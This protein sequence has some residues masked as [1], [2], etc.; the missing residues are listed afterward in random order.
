M[1]EEF[2]RVKYTMTAQLLRPT[3]EKNAA[4]QKK[5]TYVT[6]DTV[7]CVVRPVSA[8][9]VRIAGTRETFYGSNWRDKEI[10]K[11]NCAEEFP[12]TWRVKAIKREEDT[13]WEGE[14]NIAGTT[15]IL[16]P[17]NNVV[18]WAYLLE[19]VDYQ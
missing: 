7:K 5:V 2:L 9:G 11:M 8:D 16:D 13:V 18:E 4:G 10:L 1:F 3:E 14:Y 6:D 15:P 17:F 12:S 19:R